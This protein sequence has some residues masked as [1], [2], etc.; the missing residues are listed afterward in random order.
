MNK[1]NYIIFFEGLWQIVTGN[2][3][4]INSSFQKQIQF[5]LNGTWQ[6]LTYAVVEDGRYNNII[7][8]NDMTIGEAIDQC[9]KLNYKTL[10]RKYPKQ[11][12]F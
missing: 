11:K 8:I 5:E 4:P 9:C 10:L 2:F 12:G 1:G 7:S 3:S 6:T